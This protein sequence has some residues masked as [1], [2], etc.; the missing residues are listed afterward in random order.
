VSLSEDALSILLPTFL[1]IKN[2]EFSCEGKNWEQQRLC[3]SG[4]VG[5]VPTTVL[6]VGSAQ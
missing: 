3:Y 4:G 1:K 2:Y 5:H 6:A